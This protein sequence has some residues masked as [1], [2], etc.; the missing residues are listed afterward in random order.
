MNR[1]GRTSMTLLHQ[2]VNI[3]WVS[4]FFTCCSKNNKMSVN[5]WN[6][7]L[8]CI[9]KGN[10]TPLLTIVSHIPGGGHSLSVG[11]LLFNLFCQGDISMLQN[12][13]CW[14]P[15]VNWFMVR[16]NIH[17]QKESFSILP[18]LYSSWHLKKFAHPY[19]KNSIIILKAKMK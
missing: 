7:S 10:L 14:L 17:L 4:F 6:R 12:F 2:L 3:T 9:S 8:Y 13:V 16:E 5:V 18:N 19:L 11:W 1:E 15:E